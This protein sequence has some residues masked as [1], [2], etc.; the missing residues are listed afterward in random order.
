VGNLLLNALVQLLSKELLQWKT[1]NGPLTKLFGKRLNQGI[2]AFIRRARNDAL[3][4]LQFFWIEFHRAC[5]FVERKADRMTTAP[6]ASASPRTVNAVVIRSSALFPAVELAKNLNKSAS[7]IISLSSLQETAFLTYSDHRTG[8]EAPETERKQNMKKYNMP[9]FPVAGKFEDQE[10]YAA[11]VRK[12]VAE[13]L[14]RESGQFGLVRCGMGG[15]YA[16]DFSEEDYWLHP[17]EMLVFVVKPET[18]Y[19]NMAEVVDATWGTS[20]AEEN[21]GWETE[22]FD[23]AQVPVAYMFETE[24]EAQAWL[25]EYKEAE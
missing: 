17:V 13:M 1:G 10:S 11:G 24:A 4:T 12:T 5:F 20:A 22:G 6:T 8:N 21:K 2:K 16:L 9:S 14:E 23:C 7:K 25:A 3:E 15:G 19:A 18:D